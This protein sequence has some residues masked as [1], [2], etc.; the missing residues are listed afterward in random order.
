MV[1]SPS[2]KA[3]EIF[4]ALKGAAEA[5]KTLTYG[6]F[7]AQMRLSARALAACLNE[8]QGWCDEWRVPHLSA[9]VVRKETGLPGAGYLPQER[10]L[11]PAMYEQIKQKVF[12]FKWESVQFP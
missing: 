2:P 9:L 8:I 6:E 7:A 3:T 12:D 4:Q 11:T 10:P 5:Q 1:S